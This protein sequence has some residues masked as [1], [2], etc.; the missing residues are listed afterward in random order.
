MNILS[1]A[2]TTLSASP[3]TGL[4]LAGELAAAA[5]M[6]ERFAR[7]TIKIPKHTQPLA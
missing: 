6:V 7:Q 2:L 1:A 3:A 4:L 5:W